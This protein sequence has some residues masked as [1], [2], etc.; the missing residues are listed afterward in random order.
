[1]MIAQD[2]IS[3]SYVVNKPN[4][5][6]SISCPTGPTPQSDAR[7][8]AR[9]RRDQV[10]QPL[11]E[12]GP[13]FTIL[14]KVGHNAKAGGGCPDYPG[15]DALPDRQLWRCWD[16]R[17]FEGEDG[18]PTRL[19]TAPTTTTW[20]SFSAGM[21]AFPRLLPIRRYHTTSPRSCDFLD[22]LPPRATA[23]AGE[24]GRAI[25]TG[26]GPSTASLDDRARKA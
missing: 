26:S 23:K 19:L 18:N 12:A 1:M 8:L 21:V 6:G 25:D 7:N 15:A 9:E 22:I 24:D 13:A 16:V 2:K 3:G 11:D 14:R 5:F 10:C 17:P 20:R 4:Q